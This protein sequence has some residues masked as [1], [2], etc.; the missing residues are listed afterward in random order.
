M[1]LPIKLG[2]LLKICNAAFCK[3]TIGFQEKRRFLPKIGENIG[4]NIDPWIAADVGVPLLRGLVEA[5]RS[6]HNVPLPGI[7]RI[8]A[9]VMSS[10]LP[11]GVFAN[12]KSKFWYILGGLEWKM[13]VC[14]MSTWNIL[15]SFGIFF[16]FWYVVPRKSGNP[17][18]LVL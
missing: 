9:F 15:W 6:S 18:G 16:L 13:F 11:D 12:N 2:V 5:D 17:G 8:N 1:F 10:G 7:N 14:F 4:H 3:K